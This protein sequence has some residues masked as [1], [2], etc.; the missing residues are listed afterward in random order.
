MVLHSFQQIWAFYFATWTY[1]DF[2]IS[3]LLVLLWILNFNHSNICIIL[4]HL[5]LICIFLINHDVHLTYFICLSSMYS[6]WWNYCS[7]LF[8]IYI[9]FFYNL[10]I[11]LLSRLCFTCLI[12]ID[13]ILYFHFYNNILWK[14]GFFIIIR[15]LNMR[16]MLLA[17]F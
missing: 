17:K 15:K 2:V 13:Y 8:Q 4:P 11:N 6:L 1:Q 7:D 16:F 9:I 3:V 12:Q 10:I 5:V 14:A